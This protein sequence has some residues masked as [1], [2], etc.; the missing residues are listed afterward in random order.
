MFVSGLASS[1]PATVTYTVMDVNDAAQI[2]YVNVTS[3]GSLPSQC[4][5]PGSGGSASFESPSPFPALNTT[6]TGLLNQGVLPPGTSQA[7]VTTNVELS[8]PAGIFTTDQIDEPGASIWVDTSNGLIVK[9][10]SSSTT[11]GSCYGDLVLAATNI[12]AGASSFS[13]LAL[14]IVVV[15]AVSVAVLVTVLLL[16]RSR[17]KRAQPA[18]AVVAASPAEIQFQTGSIQHRY[19]IPSPGSKFR[20]PRFTNSSGASPRAKSTLGCGLRTASFFNRGIED[21]SMGR[22]PPGGW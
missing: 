4:S 19:Q 21:A 20:L 5:S 13:L 15:V 22:A 9:A 2:F 3:S 8:V 6:L 17:A 11:A 7:T 14:V 16:M 18:A 1:A 12:L 10:T